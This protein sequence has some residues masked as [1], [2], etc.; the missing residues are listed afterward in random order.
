MSR[1]EFIILISTIY[2]QKASNEYTCKYLGWM[3]LFV[4]VVVETLLIFGVEI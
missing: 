2:F 3:W 1:I 4:G